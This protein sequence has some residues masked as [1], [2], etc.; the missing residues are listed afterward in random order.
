MLLFGRNFGYHGFEPPAQGR[1]S[2]TASM[3]D[4]LP[5]LHGHFQWR[6]AQPLTTQSMSYHQVSLPLS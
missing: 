4:T 6:G 1:H 5:S 2:L 3:M